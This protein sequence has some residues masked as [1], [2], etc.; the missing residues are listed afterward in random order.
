MDAQ[1][2]IV[3]LSN[4]VHLIATVIWIGWSAAL[5]LL[6]APR[7]L[8]AH[9]GGDGWPAVAMRRFPPLAYGALAALAITGMVQ[10]GAHPQYE[11]MFALANLWGLLLLI[12]H[13]LIVLSVIL[14]VWLG[15]SVSPRLRLATRRAAL[16]KDHEA[17][18]LV[19][20][21][22]ALAWLNLAAGTG[23]LLLTGLMTAVH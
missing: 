21:F 9:K 12:K 11:G 1:F 6:I 8:E 15:Q 7:A 13:A 3:G 16:G 2:W 19:P 22:R 18:L 10:M 4:S 17:A 23:V 5:P 14:I 20:R